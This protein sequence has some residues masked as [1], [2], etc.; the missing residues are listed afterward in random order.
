MQKY[1]DERMKEAN[2]VFFWK[3]MVLV[4]WLLVTL[5][6]CVHS[7]TTEQKE[8]DARLTEKVGKW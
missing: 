5:F 7:W 3:S 1:Y 2:Q 6:A 8:A 4:M